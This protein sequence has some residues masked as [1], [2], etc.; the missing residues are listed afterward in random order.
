MKKYLVQLLLRLL[1]WLGAKEAE[2]FEKQEEPKPVVFCNPSNE[3]DAFNETDNL[4]DFI[5][6][7]E[8]K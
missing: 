8:S 4:E 2:R 6:R 1:K 7:I 5:K 3:E